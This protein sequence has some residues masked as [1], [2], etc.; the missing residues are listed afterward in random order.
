MA[1]DDE[2]VPFDGSGG[3]RDVGPGL[4][5]SHW[6]WAALFAAAGAMALGTQIYL[7]REYMVALGG[8]EAAVGLGLFAWLAGIAAGAALARV[9]TAMR[10]VDVAA[11]AI[12]LLAAGG[13]LEMLVARL[14][15]SFVNVPVGE[16]LP[17]GPS[18]LLALQVF[19]FP[20]AMVGVGFVAIAASATREDQRVGE[21][22]GR[23]YVFEAIGSLAAGALASLVLIPHTRPSV[24]LLLLFTLGLSAA[25]PAARAGLIGGRRGIPLLAVASLLFALTPISTRIETATQRARFAGLVQGV[26]LLDWDDTPYE[27]VAIGGGDVH[28]LYAGGV[29]VTSFPDA[30]EDE[31]R[32][33]QLMLLSP[34]PSRVL[35]FGGIETGLLRFCLKH[36]VQRLDLVILDR[37]AFDLVFRQL[38]SAD[39]KALLDPRVHVYFQDPRRFL[40]NVAEPYDLILQLERDPATLYLARQTTVQFA[41]LVAANLALRGTYVMRFSAGPTVQVGETG[42]LGASLYRTLSQVFPVVRAA[43][44]P[45]GL[46]LAGSSPEVVTLEPSR[47]GARWR[48]R[49]IDS[50]VFA[51]QLLPE[52]Y[53]VERVGTLESELRRAATKVAATSDNRPVS[54]LYALSV[55]QQFARSAWAPILKWGDNHPMML[56]AA[57]IAPSTLL[58]VW[59]SLRRQRSAVVAAI[60]HATAV[61][62]ATGMAV[63]LMLF[64]SFQTRVGALYSEL[65]LLSALFMFGLAAGGAFAVRWLSLTLAQA[66]SLVVAALLALSFFILDRVSFSLVWVAAIHGLLLMLAGAA[67][68]AVFPCAAKALLDLGSKARS[69]ASLTQFADHGGAALAAIIAAVIFVPILGLI[70]AAILLFTLQALALA[71]TCIAK[72]ADRLKN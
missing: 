34:S 28:N 51:A 14:G 67:T 45:T 35:S 6:R 17:L 18:L 43:P 60:V 37:R 15:R 21:A 36:P 42:L 26:P 54:F 31:S 10:S 66:V 29:Y 23:L 48:E 9:L 47:L 19:V 63:S 57:G 59:L 25:T 11:A 72:R 71:V 41:R 22:I 62:G 5:L 46:L 40:A 20:G 50:D 1:V 8:D 69:A 16:L 49:G 55:R 44:G 53:P 70:G 32:A 68:G 24:G 65:G 13:F 64:F 12:G 7:L 4:A 56:G 2:K 33:H 58:L 39:R 30:T 61:T 52:L 38:D 3:A 27:H